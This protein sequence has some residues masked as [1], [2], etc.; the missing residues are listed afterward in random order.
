MALNYK[1]STMNGMYPLGIKINAKGPTMYIDTKYSLLPQDFDEVNGRIKEGLDSNI[2]TFTREEAVNDIEYLLSELTDIEHFLSEYNKI[3]LPSDIVD[4]FFYNAKDLLLPLFAFQMINKIRKTGRRATA[5][6][7]QSTLKKIL[8]YHQN[9]LLP[10]SLINKDW[11]NGYRQSLVDEGLL[12]NSVNSYLRTL[13]TIYNRAQKESRINADYNPFLHQNYVT[14]STK[15]EVLTLEQIK[16]I[17][18]VKLEQGSIA[19]SRDLFLFS[20]YSCG[21]SFLDMI[22][23]KKTDLQG[24]ILSYVR[25]RDKKRTNVKVSAKLREL[26]DKYADTEG[27]YLLPIFESEADDTYENYRK[28]FRY[29]NFLLKKLAVMIN[30]ECSLNF[31]VAE[32]TSKTLFTLGMLSLSIINSEGKLKQLKLSYTSVEEANDFV[33]NAINDFNVVEK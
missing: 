7:Y 14:V 33:L 32:L 29:H 3:Y 25:S 1:S 5:E 22:Y 17:E 12:E 27:R 9:A 21:M 4:M 24:D 15:K 23:L 11:I 30:L 2:Y 31:H 18:L 6:A 10:F 19:L 26:I 8:G 20:Y 13:R 28:K 16:C